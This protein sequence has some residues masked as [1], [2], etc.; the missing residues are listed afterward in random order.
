MGISSNTKLHNVK[1]YKITNM[2]LLVWMALL[3]WDCF[4][5]QFVE[6]NAPQI[7][8]QENTTTT[9]F[10][11]YDGISPP[12]E[13]VSHKTKTFLQPSGTQWCHFPGH[14]LAPISWRHFTCGHRDHNNSYIF[15]LVRLSVNHFVTLWVN[16]VM[17]MKTYDYSMKARQR[18]SIYSFKK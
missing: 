14:P 11:F 4:A 15:V 9:I 17:W 16:V 10:F 6:I 13:T 8:Y 18:V 3:I 12:H 2:V 7:S 1:Q 5:T